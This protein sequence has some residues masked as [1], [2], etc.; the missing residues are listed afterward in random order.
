MLV[1]QNATLLGYMLVCS[2]TPGPG[3]ILALNTTSRYGWKKGLRLVLGICMGYALV[4]LL[5]TLALYE[6]N[7]VFGAVLEILKYAGSVYMIW[8][9]IHMM[10]SKPETS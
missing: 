1:F 9:A 2:F 4:Q 3:N 5:C 7:S 6:L 8:L 10:R